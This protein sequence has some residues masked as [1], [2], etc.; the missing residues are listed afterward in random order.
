MNLLTISAL[1]WLL[2]N[3]NEFPGIYQRIVSKD[4]YN[5][6]KI[7]LFSYMGF[8]MYINE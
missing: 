4:R 5:S 2:I 3:N 1:F 7:S 6:Y 8:F